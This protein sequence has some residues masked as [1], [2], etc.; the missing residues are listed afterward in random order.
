MIEIKSRWKRLTDKSRWVARRAS[1][2]TK[3]RATK[4]VWFPSTSVDDGTSAAVTAPQ[5]TKMAAEEPI[6]EPGRE[7]AKEARA[8]AK[9]TTKGGTK[10]TT[11][12]STKKTTGA[13]PET[14]NGTER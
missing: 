9:K 12:A 13:A 3:A 10:K 4:A 7:P 6:K 5:T 11:K 2:V 1:F 14:T 8:P